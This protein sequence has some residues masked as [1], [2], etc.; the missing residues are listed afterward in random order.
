MSIFCGTGRSIKYINLESWKIQ[1]EDFVFSVSITSSFCRGTL[2]L[3]LQF[4]H[5]VGMHVEKAIV[6]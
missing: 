1:M 2:K 5:C 3:N 4:K 6:H